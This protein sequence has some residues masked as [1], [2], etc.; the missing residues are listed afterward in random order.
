MT[1]QLSTSVKGKNCR[2]ENSLNLIHL[3]GLFNAAEAAAK[4]IAASGPVEQ[5]ETPEREF[6]HV[7]VR[8]E[9]DSTDEEL[10][11]EEEDDDPDDPPVLA[12]L[13]IHEE[14]FCQRLQMDLSQVAGAQVAAPI[15]QHF[16][17]F[18]V[19]GC[20]ECREVLQC[21]PKFPLHIMHI[22]TATPGTIDQKVPS[23]I[24][25][26]AVTAIYKLA[27]TELPPTLHLPHVLQTFIQKAENLPQV[28]LLQLCAPHST[29]RE[30]LLKR[31]AREALEDILLRMNQD[32][33]KKNKEKRSLKLQRVSHY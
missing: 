14:S 28:E 20:I 22:M 25:S 21:E 3:Q 12:P 7:R 5:R 8:M 26:K 15:I 17:T 23:E 1:N 24:V 19:A 31:I 2:D 29:K 30:L 33:K 4:Q 27:A 16:L 6:G 9:E 18:S 13:S 32:L 10:E 11:A